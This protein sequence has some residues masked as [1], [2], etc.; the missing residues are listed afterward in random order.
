MQKPR[1]SLQDMD[2]NIFGILG[3]A[4]RKLNHAGMTAQADEMSTRVK[5][6]DCYEEAICIISEYVITEL[7]DE[8]EEYEGGDESDD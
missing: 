3:T 2:G 6:A 4:R 1:M 7:S 8:F 5:N